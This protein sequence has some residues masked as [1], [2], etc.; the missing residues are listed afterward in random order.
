MCSQSIFLIKLLSINNLRRKLWGRIYE[1]GGNFGMDN[2]TIHI[3]IKYFEAIM[4]FVNFYQRNNRQQK[5]PSD[6]KPVK[7]VVAK[8][9]IYFGKDISPRIKALTSVKKELLMI[10]CLLIAAKFNERDENL[11]KINDLQKECKNSFT[12]KNIISWEAKILQELKWNLLIQTPLHYLKIFSWT[13]VTFESDQFIDEETNVMIQLSN[14]NEDNL[15]KIK[16]WINKV[17]KLWEY[18]I[19]LSTL[20]YSMLQYKEEIVAMAWVIC[21][22][23]ASQFES[24]FSPIFWDLYLIKYEHV[25]PTFDRLWKF[26]HE[27]Q[28]SNSSEIDFLSSKI[29]ESKRPI[30]D[31]RSG[32]QTPIS[33]IKMN[34]M[35]PKIKSEKV[36]IADGIT[37][38]SKVNQVC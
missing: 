35:P 22:R 30:K 3:A 33:E 6:P 28:C 31:Q 34:L 21:A 18:F 14:K 16:E 11:I 10:S 27:L 36:L 20:D 32:S 1:L 26:H 2:L 13:G 17:H 9:S 24:E 25:K 15:N 23:K 19:N 29:I 38:L 8:T 5:L 4:H 12:F 7:E 37:P